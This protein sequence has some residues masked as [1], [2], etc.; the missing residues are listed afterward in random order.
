MST[1]P[2][3]LDTDATLYVAHDNIQTTLSVL[4]NPGDTVAIVASTAGWATYMIATIDNEQELVT[5]VVG[6]NTLQVSRNFNGTGAVSHTAGRKVSNFVDAAYHSAVSS[7]IQAIQKS[8]TGG[9]GGTWPHGPKF[10]SPDNKYK[11]SFND[12]T[13]GIALF[14]QYGVIGGPYITAADVGG[15]DGVGEY[16][17]YYH[18]AGNA[19]L[20]AIGK[21]FS[22]QAYKKAGSGSTLSALWVDA[23]A[24][25][26]WT[27]QAPGGGGVTNGPIGGTFSATLAH[28]T[29]KGG[30]ALS[31]NT[32][33]A[34]NGP[35]AA[36]QISGIEVDLQNNVIGTDGHVGIMVVDQSTQPTTQAG[37]D[38]GYGLIS[39]PGAPGFKQGLL[40]Y[41]GG[42]AANGSLFEASGSC[43]NGIVFSGMTFAGNVLDLPGFLL[44]PGGVIGSAVTIRPSSPSAIQLNIFSDTKTSGSMLAMGHATSAWPAGNALSMNFAAGSGS[45]GGN[46]IALFL[47]S[48]LKFAVDS[49]GGI[50][51]PGLPSV[52]PG[53][54][55]KKLYYD[56]ADGN[57]V[58]FAP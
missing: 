2:A 29:G 32:Y 30:F 3:V 13:F 10:T 8:L 9:T 4:Q 33:A 38:F 40:F 24:D 7:A 34:C 42:V 27:P 54:G 18:D 39:S 56:P 19:N 35:S 12:P 48:V 26:T 55:S 44:L 5:G 6:A 47:N 58:K 36:Q 31:L 46:F 53:A 14:T 45:F 21:S 28:S 22:I 23:T 16:H 50:A 37:A 25:G 41:P 57:R 52:N 11:W 20:A 15:G 43:Q 49:T 17:Y 1:F 51:V